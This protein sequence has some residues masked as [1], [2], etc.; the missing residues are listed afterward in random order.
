MRN[1]LQHNIFDDIKFSKHEPYNLYIQKK[2]AKKDTKVREISKNSI[3]NSR[4]V[5]LHKLSNFVKAPFGSTFFIC[6]EMYLF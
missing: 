5:M 3:I 4:D 1:I 6:F 2:I